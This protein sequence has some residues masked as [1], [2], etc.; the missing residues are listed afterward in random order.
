MRRRPQRHRQILFVTLSLFLCTVHPARP[1][2]TKPVDEAPLFPTGSEHDPAVPTTEKVLGYS[3]GDRMTDFL[4][5]Q[6]YMQALSRDPS[7]V[8]QRTYGKSHEGRP[9]RYLIISHPD[10]M[11]RLEEIRAASVRLA[12]PRPLSAAAADEIIRSNPA[13]VWLAYSVHGDEHS[14]TEAALATAYHLASASDEAT[15]R[16]LRD[17]VVIID[18]LQNPDGRERFITFERQVAGPNPRLDPQAVDHDQ[19][20]PGGRYN[21]YLFDLNRDWF[22][23]TQPETRRKVAAF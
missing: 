5:M 9:L 13:I 4:A 21:H 16:M 22:F 1:Q 15:L 19:P 7:R 8:F 2:T 12:D 3:L 17:V 18:P 14:S 6:T 23:Q 20:W 11:K 10:N